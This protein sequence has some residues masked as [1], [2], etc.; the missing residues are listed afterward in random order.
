MSDEAGDQAP[1]PLHWRV[2]EQLYQ[3]IAHDLRGT[4]MAIQLSAEDLDF[5]STSNS[6]QLTQE[7]HHA[8]ARA[9]ALVN[10]LTR[11]AQSD[12]RP[13]AMNVH[14]LIEQRQRQLRRMLAPNS[15][16]QLDLAADSPEAHVD[17]ALFDQLLFGAFNLVSA[18]LEEAHTLT[19]FTARV[20]SERLRHVSPSEPAQLLIG[21]CAAG[22][23]DWARCDAARRLNLSDP[24]A[25]D[26]NALLGLAEKARV[27]VLADGGLVAPRQ[28]WLAVPC[29]G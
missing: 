23:R 26:I 10:D 24:Q 19:I 7:I 25:P 14:A 27:R 17:R 6:Q 11:L 8:V 3:G 28:V 22:A 21:I 5:E 4:L 29:C 13:L 15:R 20:E 9:K 18:I 16:L 1:E 2:R 12:P